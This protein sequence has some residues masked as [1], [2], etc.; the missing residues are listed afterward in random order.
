MARKKRSRSR[1]KSKLPLM[2]TAGVVGYGLNAFKGYQQSGS[3]GVIWNT[4]GVDANGTF[5]MQKLIMNV[6]PLAAGIAGS[7]IASKV[8]ANKYLAKV[9]MFRL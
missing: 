2:A 1:G 5:S 7:M 3:A 8:G 4:V 9:P 6:T